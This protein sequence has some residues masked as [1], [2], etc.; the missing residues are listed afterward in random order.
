MFPHLQQQDMEIK[1]NNTTSRINLPAAKLL[2]RNIINN[3][4]NFMVTFNIHSNAHYFIFIHDE[5]RRIKHKIHNTLYREYAENLK[6]IYRNPYP[7]LFK[8]L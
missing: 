2:W 6:T 7:L 8:F 3:L 4:M 5:S 1:N